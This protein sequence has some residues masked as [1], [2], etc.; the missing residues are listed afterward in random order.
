MKTRW[1]IVAFAIVTCLRYLG[2]AMHEPKEQIDTLQMLKSNVE[3]WEA[4]LEASKQNLVDYCF[5]NGLECQL[6]PSPIEQ[7][8][9][10]EIPSGA[11]GLM[12]KICELWV[13]HWQKS[14]L[15]WNEELYTKLERISNDKWVPFDLMVWITYAESHI[16]ANFRNAHWEIDPKCWESNN[17]WWVKWAKMDDGRVDM[18]ILPSY[19]VNDKGCYLYNFQSVEQFWNHLANTIKLWYI[20]AKCETPECISKYYVGQRWTIKHDWVRRVKLFTE[21]K[22]L[23]AKK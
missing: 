10:I 20:D 1:F 5:E 11:L 12:D 14:P 17:W 22:D 19:S 9:Q 15:C 13:I 18:P 4:W 21:S 16:G 23:L 6:S 7:P 2:L 8:E 3:Y